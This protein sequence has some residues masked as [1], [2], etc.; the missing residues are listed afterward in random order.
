VIALDTNIL[1]H[2]HR[3]DASLHQA[4]SAAVKE[5]AESMRPWS[6]CFHS[7]IE[8]YG[9]ATHSKIWREPSTPEQ[10]FHQIK[11]WKAAPSLRILNDSGDCLETLESLCAEAKVRGPL[12]HDA[13]IS[14]C[15]LAHGVTELWT[16]D[17]DFSRFPALKTRN[18]LRV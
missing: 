13:R 17:R 14:A 9:V 18:P 10:V 12:I 7:L 1:I 11:A 15:C 6:I 3:R 4:A 2:A 16:V 5:L 8:F